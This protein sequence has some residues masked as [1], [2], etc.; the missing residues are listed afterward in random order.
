MTNTDPVGQSFPMPKLGVLDIPM[1][2]GLDQ[3]CRL[4]SLES[5]LDVESSYLP[6]GMWQLN[7]GTAGTPVALRGL[8]SLGRSALNPTICSIQVARKNPSPT[9]TAPSP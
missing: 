9:G 3:S 2:D 5:R 1:Q 6:T 4:Q 8:V 7:I